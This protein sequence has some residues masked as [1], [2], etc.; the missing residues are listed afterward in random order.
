MTVNRLRRSYL[1]RGLDRILY[2]KAPDWDE[3]T[4]E[5]S[6]ED[7]GLLVLVKEGI[8]SVS[9]LRSAIGVMDS[10]AERFRLAISRRIGCPLTLK[11]ERSDEPSFDPPGVASARSSIRFGAY[12]KGTV[13]PC[14]PPDQM[15]QLSELA[16]RWVQTLAETRNFSGYPDE[17]LK[18][19]YLLI[20]ELSADHAACLTDEQSGYLEEIGWMR[21]FVS[22]PVCDRNQR[23]CVFISAALPSA[24]IRTE[25]KLAV[26]FDRTQVEHRNFIARYES[27]ARDIVNPML[28][29]AIEA[30]DQIAM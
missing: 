21:D 1:L 14:D 7:E 28:S 10:Q 11:L 16:G 18:R 8:S 25:P 27:R 26:R 12:A 3:G 22:H 19:L 30:L 20:E 17:S 5:Q 4:F 29:A 9:E 24:V 15:E 13:L 23:M 2:S 6:V